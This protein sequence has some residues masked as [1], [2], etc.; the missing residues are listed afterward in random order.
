MLRPNKLKFKKLKSGSALLL[1]MFILAGMLVVA[2][3]G[4]YVMLLGIKAGGIQTQSTKAY[5]AAEAGAE[6]LLYKLRHE[7]WLHDIPSSV[8]VFSETLP[9][10]GAAYKVYYT[11]FPPLIFT[12]IGEHSNTK[13]SVEIIIGT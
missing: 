7:G 10:S 2:M 3:S 6:K 12:S 9:L 8:V 5:F 1:T 4:A 11:S 13:R